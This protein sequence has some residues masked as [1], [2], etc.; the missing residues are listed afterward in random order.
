LRSVAAATTK[1]QKKD[2][3]KDDIHKLWDSDDIDELAEYSLYDA[4][5]AKELGERYL[6]VEEELSSLAKLP[7]FDTTLASS[8]QL[9]ENLLMYHAAKKDMLVPP[10]PGGSAIAE[11]MANPIQGAFVKLPEPGVYEN[12]AVLDF[13]SLYPTVIVSYNIDP[14]SL[15]VGDTTEETHESPSG[16]RFLKKPI[17]LIPY[18]LNMLIE[19]RIKLKK[20]LKKLDPDSDEYKTLLARSL[21]V[22]VISNSYYGYLAYARSRWYSKECGESVTAYGRKH[23][24]ETMDKAEKNGFGVIY[25][26]SLHPNRKIIIQDSDEKI[27]IINIGNFVNENIKN[28]DIRQFKTLSYDGNSLVFKSIK[29]A[30]KHSYSRQKGDLIEFETN[31]GK[32]VVTPQHSVYTFR[33]KIEL[34]NAKELEVGDFLISFTNPPASEMIKVGH[35]FDIASLDL[36]HFKEKMYLY[37]DNLRFPNGV[38]DKCP[39]CG[40]EVIL[41]GHVSR[42]HQDRK[43]PFSYANKSSFSYVGDKLTKGGRIPRY[44]RL[45]KKLAWIFGYFAAEGS[46]SEKSKKHRKEMI[47]FGS[48]N[49]LVIEKVKDIFEEILQEDLK[50]I[51]DFDKRIDKKT[52]YYRIQ[53][54]SIVALFKYGFGLGS[55][56][57]GKKVPNFIL[58]SEESIKLAFLNGYFEGDGI[59][60]EDPRYKTH[61]QKISTKSIDLAIG[62]QYLF[63]GLS[64]K[65]RSR[66]NKKIEHVYWL[67]RKDKPGIVDLRFQSVKEKEFNNFSLAKIKR[68]NKIKYDG[69]VYDLEV[70]GSHNFLDAEGL[71]LVH[72]TDSLMFL[73]K[74]KDE[75]LKFMN[76]I[77]ASLPEKMELELEGF[78]PRGVF[79]SKKAQEKGAKKKYALIGED[80][81][82]KIR[83]FELVR[84]DWSKIAKDTQLAVLEAILKD[85]SKEKAVRIV[86]ETIQRISSEK[87]P[88]SEMTIVTT[89]KK[90]PEDYEV[91][92]PELGAAKKAMA[93]GTPMSKG[94][95]V[96]YVITKSGNTI[97]E[98]AEMADHAKEYD[99]DYY[100]NNQILPAVMKILKELGYDE[101]SLKVG[102]KQQSLD[103]F[104]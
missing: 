35:V 90:K 60:Y 56:S 98:K 39:Y 72:N 93:R 31:Y 41:S 14:E 33:N 64:N 51:E 62:I 32:T 6:P 47:S 9:V 97:S 63:K 29:R 44:W 21:A 53:R 67:Y 38:K 37:S 85:G 68:I 104:F 2:I 11:R 91:I 30:I 86:R 103:N 71:I 4:K 7:L 95:V 61:F 70:D 15:V 42:I 94:S 87:L 17:G 23:I 83:G 79:V 25:G 36:G 101:Y 5:V 55:G 46:A 58:N 57:D 28:E 100:V 1:N 59:K 76:E 43:L 74:K 49:R 34:A 20:Q 84:R 10:K 54:S 77:N 48:Q 78:Y 75:V 22:K 80:E 13:R 52:Y 66:F 96:Q 65:K 12:I 102:G 27:K 50:I 16:A 92:S 3:N 82:I 26:D 81:R 19:F 8:G 69:P 45:T 40:K 99:P 18:V 88:L 24:T 73:Y 89:L